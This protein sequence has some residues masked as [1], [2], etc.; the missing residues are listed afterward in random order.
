M[1][2][3]HKWLLIIAGLCLGML[4]NVLCLTGVLSIGKW[5]GNFSFVFAGCAI[6]LLPTWFPAWFPKNEA[7]P[8]DPKNAPKQDK[9]A[10]AVLCALAAAW[11]VTVVACFVYPL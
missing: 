1:K 7:P 9:A 6:S 3:I 11:F 2:N 4:W 8:K 10:V 5:P